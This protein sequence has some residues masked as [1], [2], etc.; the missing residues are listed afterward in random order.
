MG[1]YLDT[2]TKKIYKEDFYPYISFFEETYSDGKHY[3]DISIQI[4]EDEV[5]HEEMVIH[6]TGNNNYYSINCKDSNRSPKGFSLIIESFLEGVDTY[7]YFKI[8]L[9]HK[10]IIFSRWCDIQKSLFQETAINI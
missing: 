9:N 4:V 6:S 5:E 10:I 1:L 8:H 3:I 2:R 7:N